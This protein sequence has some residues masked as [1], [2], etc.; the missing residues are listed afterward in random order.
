[1]KILIIIFFFLFLR[2]LFKN[3]LSEKKG[4]KYS[5]REKND[6]IIDVEYEELE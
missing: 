5:D 1:M 6:E 2:M 4:S 3:F